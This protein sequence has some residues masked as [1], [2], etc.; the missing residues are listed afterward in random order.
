MAEYRWRRFWPAASLLTAFL[1]WTI[2]FQLGVWNGLDEFGALGTAPTPTSA[3][4]QVLGAFALLTWPGVQYLV[5]VAIAVWAWR[6]RLRHLSIASI[7][8]GVASWTANSIVKYLVARPRPAS[9]VELITSAGWSY[10]SSHMS[11][12]ATIV[13]MLIVVAAATRQPRATRRWV[14]LGGCVYL[15]FVAANRLALH[16]HYVSDLIGGALLGSAVTA[17]V[18][19]L[20]GVRPEF[21]PR[22]RADVRGHC[23][24]IVNPTK[25]EDWATLRRHVMYEADLT[26]WKVQWLE[27]SEE[28]GAGPAVAEAVKS[29]VELIIAAG[30]DGTVRE[31]SSAMVGSTARLAILPLG[32]GNLLARNLN[33][34]LDAPDAVKV[35]FGKSE[36]PI[37][38]VRLTADDR[39]PEH[40]A[41]MAGVGLDAALMN[42]TNS[43]LKRLVGPAAYFLA[44]PQALTAPPFRCRIAMDHGEE[45]ETTAAIALIGNVGSV[46][47]QIQLLPDA[48][49]DDGILDLVVASPQKVTDWALIAG[50]VIS[51]ADDPAQ[52]ARSSGSVVSI[53]IASEGDGV[54]YQLDGDT[55]GTCSRLLAEIVPHAVT[56][57]VPQSTLEEGIAVA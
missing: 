50:R 52:L 21:L 17:I 53:D 31:A 34:P 18:V 26:G 12:A 46:M 9:A 41:V 6:R 44:A 47:G 35:A 37:D 54:E 2:L 27:T 7:V 19:T 3:A 15:F 32:T 55:V 4:G 40:F 20:S 38:L 57:K 51:G 5:L 23:V 43:D 22:R 10:P 14:A 8:T 49:P 13:T 24:V 39:P 16:A 36:K 56:V 48:K 42:A 28:D 30:G 45:L 25:V 11:A 1:V 33:I 29:P